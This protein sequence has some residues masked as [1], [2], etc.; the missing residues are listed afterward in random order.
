MMVRNISQNG[1]GGS[2]AQM[3]MTWDRDVMLS[4]LGGRQS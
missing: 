1:R 3:I 2:D 4:L